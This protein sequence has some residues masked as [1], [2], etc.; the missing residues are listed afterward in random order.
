MD[1]QYNLDLVH[2]VE[3]ASVHKLDM[4]WVE[5]EEDIDLVLDKVVMEEHCM[6]NFVVVLDQAVLEEE[7]LSKENFEAEFVQQQ[8]VADNLNLVVMLLFQPQ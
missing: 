5:E 7:H 1:I 4:D 2:M 3:Q 6:D 8:A